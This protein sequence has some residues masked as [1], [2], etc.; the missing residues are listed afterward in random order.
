MLNPDLNIAALE[1]AFAEDDRVRI[2]NILDPE[3]AEQ[4]RAIC[5]SE[6]PFEFISYVDGKNVVIPPEEMRNLAPAQLQEFQRGMMQAA[7][8]GVG[9]FY[10]G[11]LMVRATRDS[12]SD[13]MKFLHG[14]FDFLNS[15]EML[16]L[17]MRVTGRDDLL[18]ADAQ[19]TRY[20]PGQ[21]LTRHRDDIEVEKRKLAYVISLSKNWH[22]DWGGLLQFFDDD[23]VPRDSWAPMFNSM[24]LFDVRHVHSVTYVTP[25][26]REP[27]LSLTGW[28]RAKPLAQ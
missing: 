5:L 28:F 25:F 19:F 16:R 13:G 15:D 21:F 7:S 22:P 23:G 4:M 20:T 8:D 2:E 6:V 3:V 9:F 27:R 18:S 1:S 14:V 26:A 24:T 17:I 11:Y 12:A 10:N